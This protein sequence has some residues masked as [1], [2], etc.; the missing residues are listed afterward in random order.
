M[1]LALIAAAV[2]AASAFALLTAYAPDLR[3][4]RGGGAHALSR[5]AIGYAGIVRLLSM[6][7]GR[8][9]AHQPERARRAPTI[10]A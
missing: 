7:T 6:I 5:S 9:G 4:A 10:P 1:V 2:F 3:A 8:A